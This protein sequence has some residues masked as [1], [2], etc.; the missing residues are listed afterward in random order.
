MSK[1][2]RLTKVQAE[3]ALKALTRFTGHHGERLIEEFTSSYTG[4]GNP[5]IALLRT[6]REESPE[7]AASIEAQASDN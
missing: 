7:F 3:K 4:Q 5:S 6:L 1:R 2:T